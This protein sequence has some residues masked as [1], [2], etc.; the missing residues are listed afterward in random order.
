MVIDMELDNSSP[1]VVVSTPIRV[2][3]RRGRGQTPIVDDEVC[4]SARLRRDVS[5]DHIQLDNEPR[6][7]KGAR[8]KSISFSSVA[9]LKKAIISSTLEDGLA[10][11]EV[12]PVPAS[13]LVDFDTSFRGA[14]PSELSLATLL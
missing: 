4:R 1:P 5:Q 10:E 11:F 12:A 6:I 2:K 13:T 14:P 3:K 9:D 7:K 8:R